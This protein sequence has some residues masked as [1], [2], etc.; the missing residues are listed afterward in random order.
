[1]KTTRQE[2]IRTASGLPKGSGERR[3]IL[4]NLKKA[5]WKVEPKAGQD[6]EIGYRTNRW[7]STFLGW[8]LKGGK[9]HMKWKDVEAAGDTTDPAGGAG[10]EWEAYLFEGR[11]VVGSS[12]DTLIIFQ[13]A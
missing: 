8:V 3:Q 11:V 4:S 2:M 7:I 12:A 13:K 6:Y 5:R 10:M 9:P 1:M